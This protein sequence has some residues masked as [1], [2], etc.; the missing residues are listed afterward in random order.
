MGWFMDTTVRKNV[1]NNVHPEDVKIKKFQALEYIGPFHYSLKNRHTDSNL[2]VPVEILQIYLTPIFAFIFKIFD[3]LA[4][5]MHYSSLGKHLHIDPARKV[6][7][8]LLNLR[9]SILCQE[10]VTETIQMLED[11][12]KI[13]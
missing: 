5:N 1:Y 3:I 7:I 9:A 10:I 11:T 8:R 6:V 12:K 2:F 4:P 13:P